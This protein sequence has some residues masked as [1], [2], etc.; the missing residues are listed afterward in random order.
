MK[1]TIEQKDD[2]IEKAER[3]IQDLKEILQ[4]TKTTFAESIRLKETDYEEEVD[5]MEDKLVEL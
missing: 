4:E 5:E 2:E 3:K 1:H